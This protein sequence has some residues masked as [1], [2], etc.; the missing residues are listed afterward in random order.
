MSAVVLDSEALSQLVY[1]GPHEATLIAAITAAVRMDV[2][3]TVPAAVLAELY[4]G[5]GRDQALDAFLSRR[6]GVVVTD[7]DRGL[8]RSIGNLL[9]AAGLGSREHLD[10]SLAATALRYGGGVI[11][12]GDPADLNRLCAGLP[13]IFI[14]AL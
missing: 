8:A 12:T 10:A 4:R 1:R 11:V 13:G 5:G 6:P 7:T 3:V 9:A 2:T 14:Q